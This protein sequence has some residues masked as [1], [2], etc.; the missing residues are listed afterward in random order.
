MKLCTKDNMPRTRTLTLPTLFTESDLFFKNKHLVYFAKVK[1]ILL[2]KF[3][4]YYLEHPSFYFNNS[5]L[6][7]LQH[8]KVQ[9]LKVHRDTWTEF[10]HW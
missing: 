2:L 4:S 7:C 10:S 1:K 5:E 6:Y 8:I 9:K 3:S